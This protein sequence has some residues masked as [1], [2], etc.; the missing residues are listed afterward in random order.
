VTVTVQDH[1]AEARYE[2]RV[3]SELAG[4]ADYR[5]GDGVITFVHTEVPP[6]FSGQGIAQ[7]LARHALDDARERDL[8]VVPS[9]SFIRSFIDKNPEYSD[10]VSSLERR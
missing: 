4:I 2:A 10:L 6:E 3:G 1:R 9:C 7:T 8:S 5:L